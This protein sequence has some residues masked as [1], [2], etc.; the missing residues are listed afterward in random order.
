MSK[1]T[2]LKYQFQIMQRYFNA[3]NSLNIPN[4]EIK[5]FADPMHWLYYFP[6]R[7]IDDLKRFGS[8]ID[9]RRSFIT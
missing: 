4:D 2:G 1:D 6:P 8:H 5:L 7:A 3:K 9:W